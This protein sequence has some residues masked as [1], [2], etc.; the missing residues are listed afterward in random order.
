MC[1]DILGVDEAE[2]ESHIGARQFLGDE[3]FGKKARALAAVPFGHL[4]GGE[5]KTR[6]FA[7]DLMRNLARAFPRWGLCHH[8]LAAE[9]AGAIG[10]RAFCRIQ[11]GDGRGFVFHE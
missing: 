11:G 7:D 3:H 5:A 8:H 9:A 1:G 6:R 2:G 4:D 10:R